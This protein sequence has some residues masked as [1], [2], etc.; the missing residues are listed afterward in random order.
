LIAIAEA[1]DRQAGVPEEKA[2]IAPL[3]LTVWAAVLKNAQR[4]L[5]ALTRD[6]PA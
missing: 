1:D 2:A 3:A 5:D 6:G 4:F